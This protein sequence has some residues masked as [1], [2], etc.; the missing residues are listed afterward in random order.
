M[1]NYGYLPKSSGRTGNLVSE[2]HWTKAIIELQEFL[3]LEATGIIDEP[4]QRV[5]R[6]PRCG[7]ADIQRSKRPRRYVIQGSKWPNPNLTWG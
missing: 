7:V 6:H 5:M 4:T 3:N 2:E 1:E